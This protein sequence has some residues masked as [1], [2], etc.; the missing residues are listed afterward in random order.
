MKRLDEKNWPLGMGDW[1]V[2]YGPYS[3]L[4]CIRVL[5]FV[6]LSRPK[7]IAFLGRL[8]G[9]S[10]CQSSS[11]AG[12]LDLFWSI[13]DLEAGGGIL[14]DGRGIVHALYLP[15]V[16]RGFNPSLLKSLDPN[17]GT[18]KPAYPRNLSL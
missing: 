16:G 5:T 8:L 14:P 1:S 7:R 4:G 6:R 11:R 3:L 13:L 9:R 18:V 10:Y 17:L 12:S 2:T 15:Q